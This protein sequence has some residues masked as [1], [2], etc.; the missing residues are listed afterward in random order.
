MISVQSGLPPWT[1]SWEKLTDQYLAEL[2]KMQNVQ[3]RDF[4][5]SGSPVNCRK[6]FLKA[7]K[8][9]TTCIPQFIIFNTGV[10]VKKVWTHLLI[11]VFFW[12]SLFYTVRK[13]CNNTFGSPVLVLY[14][15]F[16]KTQKSNTHLLAARPSRV[17]TPLLILWLQGLLT[18][19]GQCPGPGPVC[20]E[21]IHK[22]KWAVDWRDGE[23]S[24]ALSPRL[25]VPTSRAKLLS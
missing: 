20:G 19:S 23:R 12:Y 18:S 17:V 8:V 9:E 24:W 21:L 11:P 13:L 5:N 16:T 7:G 15:H 14:W 6:D 22:I 2:L 1:N 10:P 25:V 4:C 3:N